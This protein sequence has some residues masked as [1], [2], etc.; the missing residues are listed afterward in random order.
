MGAHTFSIGDCSFC[1]IV[2]RHDSLRGSP[3]PRAL[4]GLL[5]SKFYSGRG[6]TW[7]E[8]LLDLELYPTRSSTTPEALLGPELY[9]ARDSTRLDFLLGLRLYLAQSFPRAGALLDLRL[10]SA[11]SFTMPRWRQS[12]EPESSGLEMLL[13][14]PCWHIATLCWIMKQIKF[15]KKEV[16]NVRKL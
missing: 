16:G 7:P 15:I 5:R 8:D 6:S 9:P 10:Y 11:R 2:V 4:P 13:L 1:R 14:V 12:Q 3:R